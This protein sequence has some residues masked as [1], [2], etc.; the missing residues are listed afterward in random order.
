MML[1]EPA[2]NLFIWQCLS[3]PKNMYLQLIP[4]CLGCHSGRCTFPQQICC[5]LAQILGQM[6]SL[7]QPHITLQHECETQRPIAWANGACFPNEQ[8]SSVL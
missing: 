8:D 3:V 4:L 1:M 6:Q 2:T 7:L 5:M